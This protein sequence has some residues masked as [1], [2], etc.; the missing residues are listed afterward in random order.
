MKCMINEK[1]NLEKCACI[2]N[3][4]SILYIY[5]LVFKTWEEKATCTSSCKYPSLELDDVKAYIFSSMTYI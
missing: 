2:A 1:I 4:K 5:I 3:L